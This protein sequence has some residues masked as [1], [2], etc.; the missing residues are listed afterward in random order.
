MPNNIY[1]GWDA[2]NTSN[3]WTIIEGNWGQ[4]LG[5]IPSG[6]D[7]K[8]DFKRLLTSKGNNLA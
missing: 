4:M 2:A 6:Q 7:I 5:Q 1:I 3:S 8:A